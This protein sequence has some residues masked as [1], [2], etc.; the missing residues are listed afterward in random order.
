M[1]K[2][3]THAEYVNRLK[4]QNIKPLDIYAGNKVPIRH[5]C[6]VDGHLWSVPPIR[7]F[8]SGCPECAK[9]S[10]WDK[11][12]R[13]SIEDLKKLAP[14]TRRVLAFTRTSTE[15]PKIQQLCVKCDH[16]WTTIWNGSFHK[17]PNCEANKTPH[18]KT[19]PNQYKA[20][21]MEVNPE[22]KL[23][24][25]Y[26]GSFVHAKF[27]HSC[28]HTWLAYPSNILKGRGCPACK[29]KLKWCATTQEFVRGYEPQAFRYIVQSK[30]ASKKELAV[31]D[32]PVIE[33]R[34]RGKTCRY[35]PDAYIVSQNRIVEVKS[36]G[37]LGIKHRG[38]FFKGNASSLFKKTVAKHNAC[39]DQGFKFSLL[40]MDEKGDRLRLPRNWYSMTLVNLRATLY[41]REHM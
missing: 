28:G 25:P 2:K 13:I 5:K 40:L 4:A 35:H 27:K 34:F 6:L 7:L 26:L 41:K 9:V 1:T 8:V 38:T 29:N 31:R 3:V 14:S 37:T 20:K 18:N 36:V 16:T 22:I 17:C 12:G 39:V 24:G 19:S 10:R 11:R 30:L 33:Y 23:V 32:L 15:K 21:L